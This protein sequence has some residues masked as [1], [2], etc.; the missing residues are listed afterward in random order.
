MEYAKW[1]APIVPVVKGDSSLRIC[2]NYNMSVNRHLNV[3]HYPLPK[4]TNLMASV[5]VGKHFSKLDLRAAYQQM[6]LDAESVK[7]VTINTQKG[8]KKKK[9]L[10]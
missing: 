4:L 1:A 7:L 3:D 8:V 9:N 6:P 2:S 5:S 10:R